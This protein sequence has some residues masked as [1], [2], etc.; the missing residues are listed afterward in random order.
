MKTIKY[1]K[2]KK[3][4][5]MNLTILDQYDLRVYQP[6][7]KLSA[8]DAM[9]ISIQN[10]KPWEENLIEMKKAVGEYIDNWDIR[11]ITKLFDTFPD[12]IFPSI[13]PNKYRHVKPIL[14]Y[15]NKGEW[16]IIFV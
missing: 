14:E 7:S 2:F 6:F 1:E 8:F 5:K 11:R 10:G 4:L 3:E 16:C 9:T 12:Y 15:D 13:I